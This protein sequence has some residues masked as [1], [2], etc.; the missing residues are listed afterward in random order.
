MFVLLLPN[1]KFSYILLWICFTFIVGVSLRILQKERDIL[2]DNGTE[3][4]L[5][6]GSSVC[7]FSLKKRIDR[8]ESLTLEGIRHSLIRQED[9]IIFGLLERSQYCYNAETYNPHAFP[10][11]GFDGSLVEFMLKETEK[12][13]G[14]V[15]DALTKEHRCALSEGEVTRKINNHNFT[16]LCFHDPL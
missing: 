2:V 6:F 1:T 14:Q 16:L 9:S 4:A 12:L 8:S 5:N 13:H 7:R 10:M 3:L 15:R 11:D